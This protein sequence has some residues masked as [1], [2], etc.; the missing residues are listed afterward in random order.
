MPGTAARGQAVR[1]FCRICEPSCGLVA[2]VDDGALVKLSPDRDHA[3]TKGFACHKGLAAVDVHHD[4]A[5]LDVPLVRGA[6]GALHAVSWAEAMAEIG[7]RLRAIVDAHGSSAIG[8]Y[9]GNPLAFNALGE[10]HMVEMLRGLGVRRRFSAGTQDCA[11]KWAASEAVFGTRSVHPIPDLRRTDLCL[12][13]GE[14]PRVSQTSFFSVPNVLGEMRRSAGRGARFVFVNPRRIETPERGVGD[15]VLIR[16]DTDVW[17]LAALLHEID[18]LGG[19][20]ESVVARHG[21]NVDGLR[22]FIGPYQADAVG[23]VTG[24]EP[25]TIRELARAW[26]DTPRASVHASTGLNMGRQGTLAY[27]LVHMLSFVTGH[28]DTEGG[29]LKSDGFYP[30]ARSGAGDPQ[31]GYIDT[32]FGKLRRGGMP[33]TLLSHSILDSAE[34]I[35]AMIVVAGNPLLSIPGERRLREAFG[36][37]ELLVSV[38]IYLNATSGLAHVVLPATDMYERDDL[39]VINVGTSA[40]PFVQY[41]PAV[42][43]AKALRRPEWWIAHR[44][45]QEMG[46][47]SLLDSEQPDP[48][49]KLRYMLRSGSGIDL[50][51]LQHSGEPVLLPEPPPGTF[52]DTQVHTPDGRVDCCPTTFAAAIGR[53]HRLFAESAAAV[54]DGRLLL[55]HGRDRWMH[56]SWIAS[57]RP[58]RSRAPLSMHPADAA[59]LGLADGDAIEVTSDHGELETTVAIDDSLM[60]GVVWMVHGGGGRAEGANPNALLPTGAGSYEPLSSQA[61]MTGIPVTV[62]ASSEC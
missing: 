53:C 18:R 12:V 23:A 44:L 61:H 13:I 50:D 1:T 29:N 42:V 59:A 45:L 6:D 28:L 26:V 56:N 46:Q 10:Q 60:R 54:D 51:E 2:S 41:T 19:F 57:G 48:W 38:D 25:G 37:L 35:R 11:N 55:I 21:R 32:E 14:N 40:R 7:G 22:S 34:P 39:N 4:P 24:I 16:P 52:Y 62:A 17:F 5:R 30:N 49:A 9:L 15:T 3:V 31:R 43:A 58:D 8:A 36:R 20:D 33:G 27:W 47:P